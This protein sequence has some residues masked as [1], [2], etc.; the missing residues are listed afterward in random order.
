VEDYILSFKKL[1]TEIILVTKIIDI[2]TISYLNVY[3]FVQSFPTNLIIDNSYQNIYLLNIEQLS[4]YNCIKYIHTLPK[5]IK[6]IDYSKEN[7]LYYS[8]YY[9]SKYLPYQIN[10]D[11]IYNFQKHRDIC[12]II[13]E[14][15]R[16]NNIINGFINKGCNI[17]IISGWKK[18][19][20]EILFTYKILINIG[21]DENYKIFESLRCD[22]CIFN[23]MIVISEKKENMDLYHLKDYMIFDDY[24]NIV[25]K[26]ITVLNNYDMYYKSL[27]LDNLKL[28]TLPIEPIIPDLFF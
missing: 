7:M 12:I 4:R 10:Y 25:N 22:R 11:E 23:K 9:Y 14:S 2:P 18:E 28:E 6:I 15:P 24:K 5:N 19:R 1:Y 26:A 27:N 13:G 3:I 21:Y 17:D 16:R 20:D 8:D